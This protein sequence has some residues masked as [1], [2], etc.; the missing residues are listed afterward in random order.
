ME[1]IWKD[2]TGYEGIYQV[3]NLGRIKRIGN[4][5]NQYTTWK[6]E[7]ILKPKTHTNGYKTIIL[8][9]N[10]QKETFYIHR[11]VAKTFIPNPNNLPEINHKDG[12]KTKNYADNLEWCTRRE[13]NIHMY[14]ILNAK[15]AKGCY[16]KKKKVVKVDKN[17]NIILEIFDSIE[18]AAKSVNGLPANISAVCNFAKCPEKYKR[19]MLSYKGFKWRFATDKMK[20]GDLYFDTSSS[21][22]R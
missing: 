20:V 8:S 16:G 4:Y 2:I 12:D 22:E 1:E 21:S 9:K 13:N 6:S 18:L 17:T 7:K 10:N 5:S 15:R 3:S 14:K 19:K 11:L